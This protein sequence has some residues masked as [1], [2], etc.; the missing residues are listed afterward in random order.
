MKNP[1]QLNNICC[2]IQSDAEIVQ[3]LRENVETCYHP[4]GSCKIGNDEMSPLDENFRVKGVENL[5]VA[6]ASAMPNIIS[7]NTNAPSI[8]LG[9][10]CA[11]SIIN[12]F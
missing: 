6:D 9:E 3:F 8:L 7:G 2:R 5:R 4:V 11:D 10:L 1:S 12:K